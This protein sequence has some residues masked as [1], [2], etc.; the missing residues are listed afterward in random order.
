MTGVTYR[1]GSHMAS[2]DG[3]GGHFVLRTR[4]GVR[5]ADSGELGSIQDRLAEA[6]NGVLEARQATVDLLQIGLAA[7]PR[8][9]LDGPPNRAT[10]SPSAIKMSND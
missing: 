1:Y 5:L 8:W 3:A 7:D 2:T 6:I 4:I 9:S 10:S